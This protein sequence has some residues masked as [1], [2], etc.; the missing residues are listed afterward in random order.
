MNLNLPP[1]DD[2][3]IKGKVKKGFY[4]NVTEAV[5]DAVRRMREQDSGEQPSRLM[6]AVQ[7]GLDD[8]AAGR[9]KTYPSV[10][11]L[12][13]DIEREGERAMKSGEPFEYDPDVIGPGNDGPWGESLS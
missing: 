9:V 2:R 10:K 8:V 6:K 12:M 11:A 13:K 1:V 4:S 5:R 3:Y 7:K